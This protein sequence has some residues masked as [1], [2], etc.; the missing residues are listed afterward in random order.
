MM[1]RQ[2][3][4]CGKTMGRLV[5]NRS[6]SRSVAWYRF[7]RTRFYC[8]ECNVELQPITRAIGYFLQG[9]MIVVATSLLLLFNVTAGRHPWVLAL[10]IGCGISLILVL[11]L[12]CTKWGFRY[13][14]ASGKSG[15]TDEPDH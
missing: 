9:L 3:P 5:T 1:L 14:I 8:P 13:S 15:R 12:V 4:N 10:T 2:C 6:R 7:S 11:A